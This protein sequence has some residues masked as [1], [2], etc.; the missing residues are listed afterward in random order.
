MGA[1]EK[2]YYI[3]GKTSREIG[4]CGFGFSHDFLDMMIP[5]A[6]QTKK[7]RYIGFHQHYNFC[8]SKDTRKRKELT[9]WE[10]IFANYVSDKDLVT[11][12]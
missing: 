5:K 11:I 6:Q 7:N 12:L 10:E 8:I 3:S 9:K 4:L 2:I 1:R